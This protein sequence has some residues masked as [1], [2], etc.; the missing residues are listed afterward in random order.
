LPSQPTLAWHWVASHVGFEVGHH[1]HEILLWMIRQPECDRALAMRI[2]W[3]KA[4]FRHDPGADDRHAQARRNL[5][6]EIIRH[7]EL[8][9]YP[10]T[11]G[12]YLDED[13]NGLDKDH[14]PRGLAAIRSYRHRLGRKDQGVT[15]LPD[16]LTRPVSG[17]GFV[18]SWDAFEPRTYR[19]LQRLLMAVGVPVRTFGNGMSFWRGLAYT[20]GYRRHR[21]AL[22][23]IWCGLMP[24]LLVL[25][26]Y[27]RDVTLGQ[28]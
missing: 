2:F 21:L 8:H 11:E 9:G 1:S 22:V 7:F 25:C 4:G 12:S 24:A 26:L 6:E 23:L 19:H 3:E 17:T 18:E 28:V 10:N 13:C 15:K 16:L 27:L 14:V 5:A 20:L